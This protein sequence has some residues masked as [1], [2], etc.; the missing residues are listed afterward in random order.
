MLGHDEEALLQQEGGR[1]RGQRHPH[2]QAVDRLEGDAARLAVDR[3]LEVRGVAGAGLG[4]GDDLLVGEHHVVGAEGHAVVPGDAVAQVEGVDR[5]V[6][7]DVPRGG[8]AGHELVVLEV[9]L[10]ERVEHLLGERLAD[11][12]DLAVV[13]EPGRAVAQRQRHGAAGRAGHHAEVGVPHGA[14]LR[15]G[16]GAQRQRSG[17]EHGELRAS[18]HGDL[19]K[20]IGLPHQDSP[21]RDHR[22]SC[23]HLRPLHRCGQPRPSVADAPQGRTSSVPTR[24]GAVVGSG[25]R[26]VQSR[27][28]PAART[29]FAVPPR[30][31]MP[32]TPPVDPADRAL[33]PWLRVDKRLP[34]PAYLQVRDQI[35]AAIARGALPA[36]HALPSERDLAARPRAVA[37]DRAA[38]VPRARARRTGRAAPWVGHLRPRA[39]AGAD[40]RPGDRLHRRGAPPGVPPRVAAARDRPRARRRRARRRAALPRRRGGPPGGPAAHGRRRAALAAVRPPAPVAPR[41]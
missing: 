18:G 9:E 32:T 7:G 28:P 11:V 25:P 23:P 22:P 4:V 39:A 1:G 2:G 36:G 10:D 8:E 6:V 35:A 29:R 20:P 26:V 33:L 21:L 34:T 27:N 16:E 38:G 31:P 5:A 37:H 19:L 24:A 30:S 14:R 15:E 41:A 17:E 13:E 3:E 40:D 12:A